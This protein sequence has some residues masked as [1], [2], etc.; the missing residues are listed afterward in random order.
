M[1]EGLLGSVQTVGR[2]S[3]DPKL[4][5]FM[6]TPLGS[7]EEEDEWCR[8]SQT[9][10]SPQIE[11]VLRR[12][13]GTSFRMYIPTTTPSSTSA[14]HRDSEDAIDL[15]ID[16]LESVYIAIAACKADPEGRAIYNIE[17]LARKRARD[18]FSSYMYRVR[19]EFFRVRW[20]ILQLARQRHLNLFAIWTE[21]ARI[22]KAFGLLVWKL[23][24]VHT[25]LNQ[26]RW[27][28][29]VTATDSA[30]AQMLNI[31]RSELERC[32]IRQTSSW[33]KGSA[34]HY[35]LLLLWLGDKVPL[36]ETAKSLAQLSTYQTPGRPVKPQSTGISPTL[37][38]EDLEHLQDELNLVA[39]M[40]LGYRRAYLLSRT[41]YGDSPLTLY[42]KAGIVSRSQAAKLIDV[43]EFFVDELPP[44]YP[45]VQIAEI[46]QMPKS[47]VHVYRRRVRIALEEARR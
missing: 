25:V 26:D 29:F 23:P 11:A 5:R 10:I 21:S 31:Y 35:Y 19:P 46:F 13:F 7:A 43:P 18:G 38:H 15:A 42:L 37:F 28:L 12:K 14:Q 34:W 44:S 47:N 27:V 1:I 40:T 36:T 32:G 30:I 39:R 6:D 45:N 9:T 22:G 33:V 41:N 3:I 24:T 20:E 8:L 2:D 16:I 4:K 17:A